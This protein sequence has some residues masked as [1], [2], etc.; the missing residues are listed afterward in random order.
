[1]MLIFCNANRDRSKVWEFR[2]RS[3]DARCRTAAERSTVDD[4]AIGR[5]VKLFG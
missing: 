5:D 1:M 2:T 4:N 3:I